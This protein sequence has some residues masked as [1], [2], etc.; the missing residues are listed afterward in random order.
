[1]LDLEVNVNGHRYQFSTKTLNKMTVHG[2]I[3]ALKAR[4]MPL[5]DTVNEWKYTPDND[6][7]RDAATLLQAA[8]HNHQW[9]ELFMLVLSVKFRISS[10]SPQIEP[11]RVTAEPGD[12][13]GTANFV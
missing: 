1:M 7:H 6:Q 11:P 4:G 12:T 3:D 13:D 10:V 2:F 5:L 8:S 9:R